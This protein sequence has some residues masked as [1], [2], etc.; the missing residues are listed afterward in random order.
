[1]NKIKGIVKHATQPQEVFL[2]FRREYLI[3][4]LISLHINKKKEKDLEKEEMTF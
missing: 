1:M 2:V 3:F 4:F